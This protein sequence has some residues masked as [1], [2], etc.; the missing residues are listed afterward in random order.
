MPDL[1]RVTSLN[2]IS[3]LWSQAYPEMSPNQVGAHAGQLWSLVERMQEG[4]LV[5]LR[6]KTRGTIAVGRVT[7][8]YQNRRDLVGPLNH[9]RP[10]VAQWPLATQLRPKR[11]TRRP[12]TTSG[13]A[14]GPTMPPVGRQSYEPAYPATSKQNRSGTEAGQE[15]ERKRGLKPD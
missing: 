8:P 15:A 9:V 12:E 6:L 3:A 5:V 10:V 7:G 11:A 4:E 1:T 14:Q 13:A 2:E